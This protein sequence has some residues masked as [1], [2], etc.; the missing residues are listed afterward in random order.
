M[1]H[2]VN[3]KSIICLVAVRPATN[4]DPYVDVRLVENVNNPSDRS[5]G[6]EIVIEVG[7]YPCGCDN[8]VA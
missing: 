6:H 1:Y 4:L 3:R 8:W 7:I 5:S 2:W